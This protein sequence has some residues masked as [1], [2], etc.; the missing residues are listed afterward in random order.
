MSLVTVHTIQINGQDSARLI[1][2]NTK[3]IDQIEDREGKTYFRFEP[4]SPR[5]ETYLIEEPI[6]HILNAP[7]QS[8]NTTLTLA[9]TAGSLSILKDNILKAYPHQSSDR[10]FIETLTGTDIGVSVVKDRLEHV[11]EQVNAAGLTTEALRINGGFLNTVTTYAG[12]ASGTAGTANTD[13]NII[14]RVL[15][16]NS[17]IRQG[18]R[19]R[20]RTWMFISGG[21]AITVTTKING[22]D[23]GTVTHTGADEF[24]LTESWLHYIDDTH[25]NLIEQ[26]TGSGLGDLSAVNVSGIDWD[27]SQDIVIHQTA[28]PGSYATVYGI[29][30]DILPLGVV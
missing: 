22:I 4:F 24:D 10:C 27:A 23:V 14:T 21:A 16:A 1:A 9:T 7:A 12:D 6:D 25:F 8:G 11:V 30:V 3:K 26:E 28:A 13:M 5:V 19:L 17:L 20:I 15:A 18:D 2:L 29:F